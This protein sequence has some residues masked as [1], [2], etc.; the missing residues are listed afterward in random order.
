MARLLIAGM[1]LAVIPFAAG[2][3]GARKD[4]NM[5]GLLN[6]KRLSDNQRVIERELDKGTK[7]FLY[8]LRDM[9]KGL[10]QEG[11]S[12]HDILNKYGKPIFTKP[13][14]D[15]LPLSEVM[16]YRHPVKYFDTTLVYLYFNEKG[17]L[18]S[19]EKLSGEQEP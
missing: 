19:A 16:I 15:R 5:A 2:G 1:V 3:C 13:L 7:D 4:F 6:L 10:I 12:K 18:H 9:D 17:D 11:M 14:Y 8:L